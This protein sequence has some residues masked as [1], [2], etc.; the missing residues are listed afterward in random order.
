MY[1]STFLQNQIKHRHQQTKQKTT[2][3]SLKY[4]TLE[5]SKQLIL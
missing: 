2:K 4:L 3:K 5:E 1:K